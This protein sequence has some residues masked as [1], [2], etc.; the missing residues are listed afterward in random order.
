MIEPP[1]VLMSYL[2]LAHYNL[3]MGSSLWLSQQAAEKYMKCSLLKNNKL[4]NLRKHRHDLEKIWTE[5]KASFSTKK[6][7]ENKDYDDFIKELNSVNEN[8]R[9]GFSILKERVLFTGKFIQLGDEMRKL[10]LEKD[11]SNRGFSGLADSMLNSD[12]RKIICP[13]ILTKAHSLFTK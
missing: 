9:Y 1:V 2:L 6:S 8:S 4:Y 3:D 10:I 12:V 13:I 7:L 11:Y 5:T